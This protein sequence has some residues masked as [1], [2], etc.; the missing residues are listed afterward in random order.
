M[1][2]L[3]MF[4]DPLKGP[5]VDLAAAVLLDGRAVLRCRISLMAGEIVEGIAL[6]IFPHQPVPR[7]LGHDGGRGNTQTAGVPFF[8]CLLGDIEGDAIDAVDEEKI[9]ERIEHHDRRL[10]G[11]QGGLQDII[12]LDLP[13]A[14]DPHPPTDGAGG[15]DLIESLSLSG[16]QELGVTNAGY[17]VPGLHD[18]RAGHHGAGQRASPRLVHPCQPLIALPRN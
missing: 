15:N 14:H 9:G 6:V 11:V 1:A 5:A 16:G 18:D 3:Q 8:D 2:G 13:G 4:L 7:D 17:L 10:H 12:F